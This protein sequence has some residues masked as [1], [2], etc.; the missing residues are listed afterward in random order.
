[1]RIHGSHVSTVIPP[2]RLSVAIAGTRDRRSPRQ[3]HQPSLPVFRRGHL[4]HSIVTD[5]E[6]ERLGV[7][8]PVLL[9]IAIDRLSEYLLR[10]TAAVLRRAVIHGISFTPPE[11]NSSENS[12]SLLASH[13]PLER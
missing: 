13:K 5:R 1:M 4:Y 10:Q 11:N 9:P 3:F 8:V 2:N 6:I 7:L 12:R